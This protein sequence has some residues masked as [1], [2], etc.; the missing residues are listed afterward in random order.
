MRL[1]I[2]TP[3]DVAATVPVLLGFEPTDSLVVLAVGGERGSGPHLRVDHPHDAS[4][5]LEVATVI[6]ETAARHGTAETV[7]VLVS[8]TEDQNDA[9]DA[10]LG[11]AAVL[12][13]GTIGPVLQITRTTDDPGENNDGTQ[14]GRWIDHGDLLDPETDAQMVRGLHAAG[15][16]TRPSGPIT[17]ADHDRVTAPVVAAGR[18]AP[19]PSREDAGAHLQP[20]ARDRAGHHAMADLIASVRTDRARLYSGLNTQVTREGGSGEWQREE[21]RWLRAQVA[22]WRTDRVRVDDQ[23]VARIAAD[24]G[25]GVL[26]DVVT[27]DLSRSTASIDHDLWAD[28]ARRVPAEHATIPL[29]LAGLTAWLYGHGALAWIACD[30]VRHHAPG[31]ASARVDEFGLAGILH[32]VLAAGMPPSAWDDLASVF[33]DD[34]SAAAGTSKRPDAAGAKSPHRG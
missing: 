20:T 19:A 11:V 4:S 29:I 6:G 9:R 8:Y 14:V 12:T 27:G 16:L 24:V 18:R 17:Q 5:V 2:K 32:D 25:I 22:Q 33:C 7:W 28:I 10:L 3:A 15:I 26:R 1:T 30:Q 23:A 13:T 31:E 21:A 34:P